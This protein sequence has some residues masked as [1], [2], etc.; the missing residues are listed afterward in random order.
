M[1][2]A[3]LSLGSNIGD[4]RAAIA[5]ALAG[6]EAGGAHI[7]AR[8]CDYRT[9]PWGVTD[10]DW[11]VNACAI[12]ETD[13]LP[14][15]LLSLCLAV[16]RS[17]GRVR[18]AKW[19]PRHID[20]DILTYGAQ[21]IESPDLAVPHPFVLER[22]FVLVPLAEIAPDLSIR[23]VRVADAAERLGREGVVRME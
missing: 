17:M 5:N 18:D 12:V 22:A 11:F 20:I 1:A 4:K 9:E 3:A 21:T 15:A 16:E 7:V 8:S 2:R 23:G 13:L 19:G 14:E 10:Q 6:L